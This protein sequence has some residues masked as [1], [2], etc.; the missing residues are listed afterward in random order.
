[1][2][3]LDFPNRAVVLRRPDL[4]SISDSISIAAA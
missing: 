4:R 2:P 3:P 1:M